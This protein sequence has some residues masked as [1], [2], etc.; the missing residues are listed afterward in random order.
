MMYFVCLFACWRNWVCV[1]RVMY[2]WVCRVALCLYMNIFEKECVVEIIIRKIYR[3]QWVIQFRLG[4][5]VVKRHASLNTARLHQH[6]LLRQPVFSLATLNTMLNTVH[7]N[8]HTYN[9]LLILQFHDLLTF[10]LWL[11]PCCAYHC[12]CCCYW[13]VFLLHNT[14]LRLCIS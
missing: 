14:N 1:K 10:P 3:I 11:T 12:C 4:M 2:V 7:M 8:G 13:R 6:C 5:H 9:T